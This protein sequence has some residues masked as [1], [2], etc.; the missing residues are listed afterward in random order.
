MITGLRPETF[1]HLQLNAGLFL[2]GFQ[3]DTATSAEQLKTAIA[4][5]IEAGTGVIGATTGDGTFVCKP[6]IRNIEANGMRAPFVGSTVNDG[7]TVT[8]TGTMKEITPEN[9]ARALISADVITPDG[10]TGVKQV[11]LR[12]EIKASDY[13]PSLCWVG[14]TS[15]GYMLI[16][17]KNALNIAGATF[18]FKDKGEGELPFEF[19]AHQGSVSDSE[20]APCVIVYF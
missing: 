8:M 15:E 10:K 18:T 16:E 17:L 11:K 5:F 9:M 20:Y 4:S 3:Y 6:E 19:Q 2:V 13:I 7:W 1:K 12:N 14:D